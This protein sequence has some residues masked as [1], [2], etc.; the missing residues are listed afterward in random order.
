MKRI[1]ILSVLIF[2]LAIGVIFGAKGIYD[3]GVSTG[4]QLESDELS[5]KIQALGTAVEEKMTIKDKIS[6]LFKEMPETVDAEGIDQYINKLQDLT[7]EIKVDSMK[8][9][10]NQYLEKWEEF[11]DTYASEDNEAIT[12]KFNALRTFYENTI[13]KFRSYYD[14]AIREALLNL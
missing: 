1:I 14:D 2:G 13:T 10:M 7:K 6:S 11:R 8:D 5:E 9:V 3:N 12:E 4:K